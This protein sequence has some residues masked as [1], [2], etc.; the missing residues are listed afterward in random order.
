MFHKHIIIDLHLIYREEVKNHMV[1][2]NA[3]FTFVC[4][5]SANASNGVL[6]PS[7][8]RISVRKECKGILIINHK[9]KKDIF[10][11]S[12]FWLQDYLIEIFILI[13][14]NLSFLISYIRRPLLPKTWV[15]RHESCRIGRSW[16]GDPSLLARRLRHSS[17]SRQ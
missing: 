17:S 10:Y 1:R 13:S 7:I 16:W 9:L 6:E 8:L 2:W 4:K 5:M 3:T 14:V 11:S 15:R 12:R